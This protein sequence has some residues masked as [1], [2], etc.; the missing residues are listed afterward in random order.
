MGKWLR[1]VLGDTPGKV[2][3]KLLIFSLIVGALLNLFGWTPMN[4]FQNLSDF[5]VHLWRTGFS[6]INKLLNVVFVGAAV[7][8]P[9]FILIRLLNWRK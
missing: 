1:S 9:I 5:F 6:S 7:V 4:V 3:I 2:I 8:I